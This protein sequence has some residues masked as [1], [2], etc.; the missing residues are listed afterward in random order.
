MTHKKPKTVMLFIECAEPG[1]AEQV[2]Y[3]LANGLREK[4]L[5]V[6]VLCLESGWLTDK[7]AADGFEVVV[8]YSHKKRDLSLPIRIAGILKKR[9]I[10]VLHSHLLDANFYGALAAVI[11][12]VRHVATDH[13]DVHLPQ[14]KKLLR[15]KL[16]I[17]SLI[18]TH[19]TGVSAYTVEQLQVNGVRKRRLS[20]IYNPVSFP[21]EEMFTRRE[22][23]RASFGIAGGNERCWV[24]IH[25]GML[26][27]VKDQETL[28]RAF[29]KVVRKSAIPQRLWIVGDGPERKKLEDLVSELGV[30]EEVK[31]FGIVKDVRELYVAAD[32]L[33]LSSLSEAMPMSILEGAAANLFLVSSDVGGVS[34][35]IQDGE[36][37]RLFKSRDIVALTEIMLTAVADP[38]S[39][40][41]MADKA[42]Q[43]A[44]KNFSLEAILN[45]YLS[46]YRGRTSS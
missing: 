33:V 44:L 15:L 3:L 19:Y 24:W 36:T 16:L 32:G 28:I 41:M 18:G 13:G 9:K 14:R 45:D 6:V 8:I 10:D 30:K 35:V 4:G 7:L 43:F 38:L 23:V 39:S 21:T 46:L 37:G 29:A 11:T 2:V 26:R 31:F 22:A 27:A 42:R 25:V 12:G 1:G 20:Q 5:K 17:S 34:E 40:Q